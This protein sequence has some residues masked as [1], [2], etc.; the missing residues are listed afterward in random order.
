[1]PTQYSRYL[2]G[3]ERTIYA[4]KKLG[5]TLAFVAVA[6]NAGGFFA[7]N[8]YT[9]NMTGMILS[10][11]DDIVLGNWDIITGAIIGAY[12]FKYIGYYFTIP[13]A[14][15]LLILAITP[16]IDDIK[17]YFKKEKTV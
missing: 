17:N 4:D 12:G 10:V 11:A 6:I 7:V 14:L 5:W 2:I 3:K 16:I 8:Q 15:I 1:M 13:I 9:S